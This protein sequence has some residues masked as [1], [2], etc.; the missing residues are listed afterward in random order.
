MLS[1]LF[2][3]LAAFSAGLLAS[4]GLGGGGVLL[5]FLTF[6][7]MDQLAAQG[8][9]LLFILPTGG[10]ALFLH[11]KNGFIC[12]PAALPIAAG[13]L[14]GLGLGVALAGLLPGRV[15]SRL[16]GLMMGFLALREGRGAVRLFREEGFTLLKRSPGKSSGDRPA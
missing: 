1:F 13:G 14:L 9:N 7:G 10:L 15:L 16:F 6:A 12:L 8:V 11:R 4:L 3:T 5:L 2:S